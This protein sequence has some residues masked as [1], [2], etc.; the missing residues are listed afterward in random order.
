MTSKEIPRYYSKEE[1]GEGDAMSQHEIDF[2]LS[3]VR[4]LFPH[5][6]DACVST[7]NTAE[8]YTALSHPNLDERTKAVDRYI[9]GHVF[10]EDTIGN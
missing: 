5:N 8:L 1:D 9:L 4:K 3:R 2:L 10:S 6:Q 7:T